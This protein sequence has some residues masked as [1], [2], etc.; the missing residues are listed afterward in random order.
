M[1]AP[2][3]NIFL[4]HATEQGEVDTFQTRTRTRTRPLPGDNSPTCFHNVDG[5][6][7]NIRCQ[8]GRSV[9][10]GGMYVVV[11]VERF[12]QSVCNSQTCN[13][14]FVIP[15]LW[16]W[17]AWALPKLPNFYFTILPILAFS[18]GFMGPAGS[19]V[20]Q[21]LEAYSYGLAVLNTPTQMVKRTASQMLLLALSTECS[22]C[23]C[24]DA[25]Y[26]RLDIEFI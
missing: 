15:G 1:Q 5:W 3:R 7:L 22:G 25:P 19:T 13:N 6:R 24:D 26:D 18:P 16:L 20:T 23:D 9:R 2:S 12:L 11:H 10:A 21:Q 17:I 4:P 8:V 14:R